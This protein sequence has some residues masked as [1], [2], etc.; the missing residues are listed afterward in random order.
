M[1]QLSVAVASYFSLVLRN[2]CHQHIRRLN[3]DNFIA[4]GWCNSTCYSFTFLLMKCQGRFGKSTVYFINE[5]F[6]RGF[7]KTDGEVFQNMWM[8][9][10]KQLVHSKEIIG[11]KK[12][13]AVKLQ[14]TRRITEY[15]NTVYTLKM[16]VW[17]CAKE[18]KV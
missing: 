18:A 1:V 9:I 10:W 2:T 12:V 17:P 4:M 13:N 16:C 11:V 7:V 5:G 15:I 14:W 8:V 3:Q 6:Q